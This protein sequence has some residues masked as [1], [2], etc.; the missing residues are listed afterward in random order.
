MLLP[1]TVL[2]VAGIYSWIRASASPSLPFI[3]GEQSL[4]GA[5]S[6]GLFVVMMARALL[7][8]CKCGYAMRLEVKLCLLA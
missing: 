2:A 1:L 3:A 5:L 6:A 4:T 8:A 7:A